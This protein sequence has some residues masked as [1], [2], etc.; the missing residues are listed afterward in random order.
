MFQRLKRRLKIP[1]SEKLSHSTKGLLTHKTLD[2]TPT[3]GI[4]TRAAPELDSTHTVFGQVLWDDSTLAWFENLQDIPTY[5]V[6]R[7]SGYDEFQTGGVATSV[8]NAQREFFRGAAKSVGDTRVSKLY[9]GKL[10]RRTEVL[11]VGVLR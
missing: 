7:P 8:Y 2:V 6:D 3:F 9:D 5:S 10:L 11:R 4:T 1:S